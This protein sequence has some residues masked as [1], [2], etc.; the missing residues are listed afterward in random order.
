MGASALMIPA[1][2]VTM[3]LLLHIPSSCDALTTFQPLLS[4]HSSYGGKLMMGEED[5]ELEFLMESHISRILASSKNYQ[6]ASTTNANKASGGGCDRPPRYDS[7]LGKKRN[8]PPP[9]NCSPYN[10]ANPC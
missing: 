2:V 4:N 10:R 9:P 3:I 8:N 7:C 1:A 5:M 6:T